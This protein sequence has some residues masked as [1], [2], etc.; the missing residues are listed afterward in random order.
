MKTEGEASVFDIVRDG[1]LEELIERVAK[2]VSIINEIDEEVNYLL[3]L[4]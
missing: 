3:H 4:L 2:N 1:N